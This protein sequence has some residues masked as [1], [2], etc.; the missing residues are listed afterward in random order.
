MYAYSIKKAIGAL[1]AALG[2]LDGIVFSGG[3]GE[4]APAVR[5]RIC[6]GLSF[7]GVQIDA[8]RNEANA[9]AISTSNAR[10]VVRVIRT[11][12]ELMIARAVCGL[13]EAR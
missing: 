11:D 8:Q 12:E 10:V 1:A 2:G 5:A 6:D 7:L 3:I 13:L 4:H 9:P